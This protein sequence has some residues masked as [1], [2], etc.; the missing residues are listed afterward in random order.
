[1]QALR[2]VFIA[3]CCL[4][5]GLP[6]ASRPAQADI[7]LVVQAANPVKSLTQ[8]EAVD[9]YTGRSRAF[10]NGDMA[11]MFDLPRDSG[12][13]ASFY[14]ALTGMNLAQIN[15]YWARLMFS[16]QTMPP[17]I[18]P[19]EQVMVDIVRRNPN[20]LGYLSQEPSDKSLRTVLVL[21]VAR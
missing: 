19:N 12:Q 16:G 14:Q 9:L 18:L 20:A 13:R 11:I 21:K 4:A 6:L 1:M 3:A 15:S 7:Y 5:L 10:S 17:Q 8:K 2:P